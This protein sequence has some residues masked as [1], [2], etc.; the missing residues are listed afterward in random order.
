MNVQLKGEQRM[1]WLLGI[2]ILITSLIIPMS[3]AHADRSADETSPSVA[4]FEDHWID[5]AV[6]WEQATACDV[7]PDL[8]ICYHTEDAMN[9]EL[10]AARTATMLTACSTSLR[11]YDGASYTGAVLNLSTRT[12]VVNLSLYGFDNLTSSYKV[13]ACDTDFYSAA[14]LGGSLY[15]GNTSAGFQAP[16]MLSGWNNTVSSVFIS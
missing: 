7:R 6:S 16:S 5:L 3:G 12:T 4:W 9:A 10:D 13:G 15:A 2:L 8:T 11:L 1:K 14:N